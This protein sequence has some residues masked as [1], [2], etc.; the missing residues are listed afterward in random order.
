MSHGRPEAELERLRIEA[1]SV[2]GMVHTEAQA[3]SWR[4]DGCYLGDRNGDQPIRTLVLVVHRGAGHVLF[5]QRLAA[6]APRQA[7]RSWR[8]A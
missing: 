1:Y 8:V 6:R 5:H 3:S 4:G 2:Q 7:L